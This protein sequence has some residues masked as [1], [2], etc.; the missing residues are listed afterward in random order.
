VQQEHRMI[1]DSIKRRDAEA[2]AQAMITHIESFRRNVT[3]YL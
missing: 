3:R 2:A 1:L